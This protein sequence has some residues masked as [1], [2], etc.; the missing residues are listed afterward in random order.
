MWVYFWALYSV[1]LTYVCLDCS[2]FVAN[3]ILLKIVLE[4]SLVVQWLKLSTSTAKDP[5]SISG[6]GTKTLQAL[7]HGTHK[8]RIV[9]AI[10][11]LLS[12]VLL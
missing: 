3:Y 7:W 2:S 1:S 6:Q 11:C 9:L 8:K 12:F 5:G 4:N 10:L